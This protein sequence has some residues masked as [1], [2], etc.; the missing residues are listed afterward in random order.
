MMRVARTIAAVVMLGAM[1]AASGNLAPA[2]AVVPGAVV[3]YGAGDYRY[4]QV[5]SGDGSPTFSAVGFD[6]NAFSVGDAPFGEQ[7]GFGCP[8]VPATEWSSN[9]DLLVR[10]DVSLPAG[11]NA[12]VIRIAVDNDVELFWNGT[13]V[14]SFQHEGCA[15]RDSAEVVIPDGLLTAGN[16]VLAARASDRGGETFLD[17]EVTA[18][19]PPDCG[20]VTTDTTTL[21]PPNHDLHTVTA[22]GG[23]DPEGDAVALAV[24]SVTSDE[25]LD[26]RGDGTT[27]ADADRDGLPLDQVQIRAE[28]SGNGDGRVYRLNVVVTDS[29]GA[30]CSTLLSIGVPHDEH[31]AAIDT[32]TVDV[33][34]FGST[35]SLVVAN[36][37]P[38]MPSLNGR[39][40]ADAAPAANAP[41]AQ[42]DLTV[43]VGGASTHLIS[44]V[45]T[46]PEPPSTVTS[47]AP[48]EAI[49]APAPTSPVVIEKQQGSSQTNR[50]NPPAPF[51]HPSR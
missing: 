29:A 13:S 46:P 20:S 8:L 36:A 51:S 4:L 18:N 30:S 23:T 14:G 48:P 41:P 5:S 12:V 39:D 19:L 9:T 24:T 32:A 34:S 44:T 43:P 37:E 3:P 33:D 35:S 16:N 17:L 21:W 27:I 31:R 7:A 26:D 49:T 42:P 10:R 6:D 25:P 15:S 38:P 22:T 50:H 40:E 28:R 45:P 47:P 2:T 1:S 11:T